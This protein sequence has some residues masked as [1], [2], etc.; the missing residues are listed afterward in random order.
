MDD[1]NLEEMLNGP[2]KIKSV[3]YL[4][5]Y[6]NA[7]EFLMKGLEILVKWLRR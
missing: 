4:G 7:V 1:F 2:K 6:R 3:K 5:L